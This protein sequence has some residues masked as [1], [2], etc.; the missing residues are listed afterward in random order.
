MNVPGKRKLCDRATELLCNLGKTPDLLDL[1]LALI[2]LECLD[3]ALEEALVGSETAVLGDAVVVLAGEET[4][5]ERRPDGGAVLVLV[6]E[7]SVLDLKALTVE[8]VVLRLLSDGSNEVIPAHVSGLV[9]RTWLHGNSLLGDLCGLHDLDSRP[10]GSSPVVRKVQV[11]DDLGEALDN[12]LHRGADIR[13]VCEHDVHVRL[14][15]PL[16]RALETLDNVLPAE[17]AS[18]GLLATSAEEDLGAQDV[19]I[20][21]PVELLERS[22]HLDLTTAIGVDLGSVEEVDAVVPGS[23]HALL[24]NVA[25]LSATVGEPATEGEDRDLETAGTKVAELHVLGVENTSDSGLRH[26]GGA[27]EGG[28]EVVVVVVLREG[29][30]GGQS[31]FGGREK[32]GSG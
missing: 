31:A 24:D 20:A 16:K 25:V 2:A 6:V 13:P 7:R 15:Q 22:A 18:V 30:K 21:R 10:L 27:V 29:N 1:G 3:G 28:S 8:S 4:R 32:S 19:L 14:L 26:D 11:A 17:A 12:L 23:L 9:D 5:S